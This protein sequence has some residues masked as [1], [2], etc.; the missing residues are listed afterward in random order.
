MM[1]E[2]VRRSM[3]TRAEAV[4]RGLLAS[5]LHRFADRLD[6]ANDWVTDTRARGN[7]AQRTGPIFHA[8]CAALFDAVSAGVGGVITGLTTLLMRVPGIVLI[9]G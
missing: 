4:R 1:A 2:D 7:V 5:G 3:E 6:S 9:V 8:P